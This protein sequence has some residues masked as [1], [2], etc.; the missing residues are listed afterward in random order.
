MQKWT[1]D[2]AIAFESARECITHLIALCSGDIAA[3]ESQVE[4]RDDA[5]ITTLKQW[6]DALAEDLRTLRLHDVARVAWIRSEYGRRA[7]DR[8]GRPEPRLPDRRSTVSR[9]RK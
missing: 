6:Q 2:Q 5:A 4:P 9:P 3:L 1:Q 8:I 7:R